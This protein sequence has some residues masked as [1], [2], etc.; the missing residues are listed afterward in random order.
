MV[1]NG[2]L[3][4]EGEVEWSSG[5]QRVEQAVRRVK[6]ESRISNLIQVN[7]KAEL[8]ELKRKIEEVLEHTPN[9]DESNISVK[10]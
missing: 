4:L 3:T 1:E 7:P 9:L 8:T 10:V 2:W 5:P 6:K